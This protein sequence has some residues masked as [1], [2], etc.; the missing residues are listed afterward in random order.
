MITRLVVAPLLAISVGL[1]LAAAAFVYGR[2]VSSPAGPQFISGGPTVEQ[3][4][5]M[6]HL[7]VLR[8]TLADVLEGQG[9]GYRGAWLLRGDALYTIDLRQATVRH[10]DAAQRTATIELPLPVVTQSRIDHRKT[11]T[12]SVEKTS[13]IPWTGDQTKLRD[14]AM[15]EAQRLVERAAA[16]SDYVDAAQRNGELILRNMYALV[17]WEITITWHRP[18]EFPGEAQ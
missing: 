16:H 6:G 9:H 7:S 8:L 10:K 3:L 18:G 13:W 15:Q 17:D 1:A 5:A 2:A 12:Y 4:E 14:A 11:M